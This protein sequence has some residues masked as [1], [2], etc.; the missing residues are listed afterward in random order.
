MEFFFL[1][2]FPGFSLLVSLKKFSYSSFWTVV[3]HLKGIKEH[4]VKSL[5]H[6]HPLA[7]QAPSLEG[8][9]CLRVFA[10]QRMCPECVYADVH[11]CSLPARG[12][13]F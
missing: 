9:G 13:Y 1:I 10:Q 6:P 5:S 11:V 2:S 7:S 4:T 3:Q 8:A 12:W